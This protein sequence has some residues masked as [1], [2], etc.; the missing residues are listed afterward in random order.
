[1]RDSQGFIH[2]QAQRFANIFLNLISKQRR[3]VWQIKDGIKLFDVLPLK[4]WVPFYLSFIV[5]L[6][7]TALT[8]RVSESDAKLILGIAF[9]SINLALWKPLISEVKKS[10]YPAGETIW[11]NLETW[12][13]ESQS[14]WADHSKKG[15]SHLIMPLW[16]H[17]TRQAT[18]YPMWYGIS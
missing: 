11:R 5:G 12:W 13:V 9:K 6:P 8:N 17:H 16:N 10:D 18:S 4:R 3:A 15:T 7:V 1:M 2:S 14:D